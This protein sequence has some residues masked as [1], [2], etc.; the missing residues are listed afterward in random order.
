MKIEK[1]ENKL[2]SKGVKSLTNKQIL[3]FANHYLSTLVE[4]SNLRGK[5]AYKTIKSSRI[6]TIEGLFGQ[7]LKQIVFTTDNKTDLRIAVS[8]YILWYATHKTSK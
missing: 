4:T 6:E 2:I 7:P 5:Y 8:S 1:I 3:T